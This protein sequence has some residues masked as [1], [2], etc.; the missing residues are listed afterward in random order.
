MLEKTIKTFFKAYKV[1]LEKLIKLP[2]AIDN[3]RFLE[4]YKEN[5]N[6]ISML[7]EKLGYHGKFNI[8]F[9]GRLHKSKRVIDVIKAVELLN[10]DD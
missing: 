1:P 3:K 9:V 2:H 7:K 6:S 4:F 5:K 10:T 8:L